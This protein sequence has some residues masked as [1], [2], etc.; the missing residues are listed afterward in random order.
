[1]TDITLFEGEVVDLEKRPEDEGLEEDFDV[2]LSG[3]TGGLSA[4]VFCICESTI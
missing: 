2:V 1:M 4:S 3:G